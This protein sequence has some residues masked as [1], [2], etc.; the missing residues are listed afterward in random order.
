MKNN[1]KTNYIELETKKESELSHLEGNSQWVR[2]DAHGSYE[3]RYTNTP[4]FFLF[5]KILLK[6]QI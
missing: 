1:E 5:N 6:T 3:F 4:N 2:R